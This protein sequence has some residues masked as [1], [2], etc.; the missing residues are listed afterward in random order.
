MLHKK[1][2]KLLK[3]LNELAPDANP[4][5]ITVL[6]QTYSTYLEAQEA[7]EKEGKVID[8]FDSNG[9]PVKRPNP[10]VKIGLDSQIQLLKLI[11]EFG[12]TPKSKNKIQSD[13]QESS[14][15]HK[16]LNKLV[17]MR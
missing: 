15:L 13:K 10:W 5:P 11:T 2:K 9:N 4:L 3:E 7:L 1:A 8:G 6:V 17:E 12:L 14:P 16:V